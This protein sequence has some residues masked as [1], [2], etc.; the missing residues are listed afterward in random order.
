MFIPHTWAWQGISSC[1]TFPIS[2]PRE[3][4]WLSRFHQITQKNDEKIISSSK[5]H[6]ERCVRTSDKLVG[7]LLW[8]DSVS[9]EESQS[10]EDRSW[11]TC[12]ERAHRTVCTWQTW[13]WGAKVTSPHQSSFCVVKNSQLDSF[14]LAEKFTIF[15]KFSLQHVSRFCV[16]QIVSILRS[17]LFVQERMERERQEKEKELWSSHRSCCFVI[18]LSTVQDFATKR[19]FKPLTWFTCLLGLGG[20]LVI[21]FFGEEASIWSEV[22]DHNMNHDVFKK[23]TS[24]W[25]L[26]LELTSKEPSIAGKTQFIL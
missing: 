3:N 14:K 16:D 17:V 2:N 7:R 23:V 5:A 9:S 15:F 19:S 22:E 13:T 25:K 12:R 11:W 26:A 21:V 1:P 8:W 18:G 20:F 4:H 6:N 10:R 24:K